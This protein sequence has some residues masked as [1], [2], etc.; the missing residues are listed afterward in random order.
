MITI[1]VMKPHKRACDTLS[2][3][4]LAEF[5]MRITLVDL[6]GSLAEAARK[7]SWQRDI[8]LRPWTDVRDFLR[9]AVCENAQSRDRT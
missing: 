2:Q 6:H 3:I 9:E 8:V 5:E 4:R 1:M 7:H